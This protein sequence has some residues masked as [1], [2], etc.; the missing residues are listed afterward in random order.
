MNKKSHEKSEELCQ[1][2]S[3]A[4]EQKERIIEH[5]T[6]ALGV[7]MHTMPCGT[8]NNFEVI[9]C[10]MEYTACFVSVCVYGATGTIVVVIMRKKMVNMV[11]DDYCV[12]SVCRRV[13]LK[14]S[15]KLICSQ[16]TL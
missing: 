12:A 6:P 5:V 11:R 10:V 3:H 8:K 14:N 16:Q 4:Y 1:N 15:A 13:V 9:K 2:S 7:A